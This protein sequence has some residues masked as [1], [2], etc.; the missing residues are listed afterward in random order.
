MASF[1]AV[2]QT[3]LGR[4]RQ[5]LRRRRRV[6]SAAV[7]WQML[8]ASAMAGGLL[9]W[10]AAPSWLIVRSEQVKVEGNQW[11]SDKAVR[12][13]VPL[14]YPQSLWGIQPQ[15][16][17]QKLELTGPIAKAKVT[18]NLFPPSLTVEV[19]ERLPVA[20]AQPAAVLRTNS[21][22][23]KVGWLDARGGWMPSESYTAAGRPYNNSSIEPGSNGGRG[24]EHSLPTLKVIGPLEQYRAS[25]PKFYQG[26]SGLTVKV[27]EIDWQDPSNLILKTEIGTVHLG[28]YSYKTAR[29]LQVLDRM[30]QLPKQLDSSK[31]AYIDLKN[32]ASPI[33]H[34]P[35]LPPG[36]ESK[37]PEPNRRQN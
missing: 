36:L 6:R 23:E 27:F 33:V 9:W 17:A 5:E 3:E 22:K 31:I 7:V 25:W 15:A 16:L 11:L 8:A 2:S 1:G 19:A 4:R 32:P 24:A 18:R 21:D 10:M 35:E 20:V 14:S 26:L 28:P 12:S 29:Q 30:R 37:T 13:L 34:L